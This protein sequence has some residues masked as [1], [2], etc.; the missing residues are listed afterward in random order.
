MS[1]LSDYLHTDWAAMTTQDWVGTILTV[2]VFVLMVALYV[3]VWRPANRERLEERRYLVF[4]DENDVES[5]EK[6]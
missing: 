2:T 6:R 3:H 1:S 5:G 4:E